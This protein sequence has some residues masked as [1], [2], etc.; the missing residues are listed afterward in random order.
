[1]TDL[2]AFTIESA[3]KMIAGTGRSMGLTMD[4]T[5][6]WGASTKED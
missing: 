5:P 1:M 2:N 3:M 6:P 4:G